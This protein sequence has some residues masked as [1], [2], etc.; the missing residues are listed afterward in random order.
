MYFPGGAHLLQ[1]HAEDVLVIQHFFSVVDNHLKAEGFRTGAHHVQRLGMHVRRD[2]EAVGVFQFAHAL[3]HRHRFRGGG[4][5]I[6]Q[7]GRGDIHTGQIQRHLLEVQQRFQTALG[8]FWLIRGISGVPARV[9]QHV[10]QDHR[11]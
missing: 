11:R 1:Q 3:R 7:R 2:E 4:G 10:T 6:Q 5:F 9:F 8:D